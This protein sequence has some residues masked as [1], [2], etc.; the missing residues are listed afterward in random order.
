MVK[1]NNPVVRRRNVSNFL[2]SQAVIRQATI[3]LLIVPNKLVVQEQVANAT[4]TSI[5]I[6]RTLRER[7]AVCRR[8]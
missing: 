5:S 1:G 7:I 3:I 6:N 2:I 8:V 4:I